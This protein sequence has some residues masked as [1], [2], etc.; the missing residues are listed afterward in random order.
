MFVSKRTSAAVLA[1]VLVWACVRLLSRPAMAPLTG[2]PDESLAATFESDIR[3]V[4][5]RWSE[6]DPRTEAER[7]QALFDFVYQT[8]DSSAWIPPEPPFEPPTS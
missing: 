5:H 1:A 3:N 8:Y 4:V 6:T 7:K 2:L